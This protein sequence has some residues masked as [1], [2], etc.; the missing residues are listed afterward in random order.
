MGA[1]PDEVP[2]RYAAG[3]PLRLV[4]LGIPAL[5]VHGSEDRTVSIALSRS[6]ARAAASAGGE[7]ELVEIPGQAGGH[8]AHIDPRGAAWAAVAERLGQEQ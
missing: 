7:V 1:G 4:P 5:L 6:Y 8:R 3:D 2:E